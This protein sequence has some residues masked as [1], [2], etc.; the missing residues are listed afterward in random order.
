MRTPIR[1]TLDEFAAER[2]DWIK[3][4]CV[5]DGALQRCKECG[6]VIEIVPAFISMHDARFETCAGP[7]TVM[8]LAIPYCPKCEDKPENYGCVHEVPTR[9]NNPVLS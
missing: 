8:R 6:V 1:V 4:K 5:T 9:R 7:G 2:M 3:Q